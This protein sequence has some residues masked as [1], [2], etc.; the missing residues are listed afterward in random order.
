MQGSRGVRVRG[1]PGQSSARPLDDDLRSVAGHVPPD[2]ARSA[3]S[4]HPWN[5]PGHG[6]SSKKR[7]LFRPLS[8]GSKSSERRGTAGPGPCQCVVG[9]P[10]KCRAAAVTATRRAQHSWG[11]ATK[12]QTHHRTLQGSTTATPSTCAPGTRLSPVRAVPVRSAASNPPSKRTTGPSSN[13]PAHATT[14]NDLIAL[15]AD[16]HCLTTTIRRFTRAGGS[17]YQFLALLSETLA[18]CDFNSPSPASPPSSC[19]TARPESTPEILS[20]V[21]SRVPTPFVL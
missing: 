8:W 5:A 13:P 6:L 4:T 2:G 21:R 12:C 10:T 16:C 11:K 15:C 1:P 17:R 20:A 14:A 3:W 9:W 19:T 18:Q 7:R